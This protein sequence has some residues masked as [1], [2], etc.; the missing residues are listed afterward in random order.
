MEG[1]LKNGPSGRILTSVARTTHAM[2]IRKVIL[3]ISLCWCY[4]EAGRH[5]P[6]DNLLTASTGLSLLPDRKFYLN[7]ARDWESFQNLW[8][9]CQSRVNSRKTIVHDY[10]KHAVL[11]LSRAHHPAEIQLVWSWVSTGFGQ[12]TSRSMS[13]RPNAPVPTR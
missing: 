11:S 3:A 4:V 7:A 8:Q 1:G 10:L 2:T 12:M 9:D 6:V 13:S 5:Q